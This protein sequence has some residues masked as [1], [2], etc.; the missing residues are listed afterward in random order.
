MRAAPLASTWVSSTSSS[1]ATVV[2]V[3][4]WDDV[5]RLALAL[6]E[7]AED[8]GTWRVRGKGFVWER[9]LRKRDLDELGPM[10]PA[11]PILGVRLSDVAEKEML[12]ASNPSVYFTT[13]HF[14]GYPA[15]LVQLA[16]IDVDELAEVITDAWLVQAPKRLGKQFLER[17]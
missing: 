2:V 4:T 8:R 12:I 6:P 1:V 9:P 11:G 16:N 7:T 5:Q 17:R 10:A 14:D 15:I 13:S 3:A